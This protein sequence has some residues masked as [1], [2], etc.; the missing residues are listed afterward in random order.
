MYEGMYG[1]GGREGESKKEEKVSVGAKL[2]II[3]FKSAQFSITKD[4]Y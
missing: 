2:S 1:V 4:Q 3:A